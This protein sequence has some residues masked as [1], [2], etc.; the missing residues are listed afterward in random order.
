MATH[1]HQISLPIWSGPLDLL[2]ELIRSSEVDIFDIPIAEITQQ[3]L[4]TIRKWQQLDIDVASDFLAMAATLLVIKSAMLL[5]AELE[6]GQDV[7]EK[8]PRANLVKQLLEYQKYKE[9]AKVLDEKEL[10]ASS[11]VDRQ[12]RQTFLEEMSLE[13]PKE[14]EEDL[15]K[16]VT[17]FDLLKIFSGVAGA[18]EKSYV[19]DE[20]RKEEFLLEDKINLITQTL[21]NK[22]QEDFRFFFQFPYIK[23]EVVITFWAVLELYRQHYL[24]IKQHKIFGNISLFKLET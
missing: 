15:W 10:R 2:L 11:V 6:E 3:Y 1:Q 7:F 20:L 4:E 18:V 8:D 21:E 24:E 12:D 14:E 23:T 19:Y 13:Q 22:K 16:N 9:I 5:P 17:L